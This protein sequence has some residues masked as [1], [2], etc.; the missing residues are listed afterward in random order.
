M[1]TV[2]LTLQ[3][4]LKPIW[5]KAFGMFRPIRLI[6]KTLAL[7]IIIRS[8]QC[9]TLSLE[10]GTYHHHIGTGYQ[11]NSSLSS[12]FRSLISSPIS[13]NLLSK[14]VTVIFK[15]A[16]ASIS[17]QYSCLLL[18]KCIYNFNYCI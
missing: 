11:T 4:R 7:L 2:G 1:T 6:A 17:F 15:I 5:K 9:R 10:Y 16:F 18:L 8:G 12:S 14:V 13:L 3:D